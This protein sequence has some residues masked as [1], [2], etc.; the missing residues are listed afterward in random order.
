MSIVWL[1]LL[2][3]PNNTIFFLFVPLSFLLLC[4]SFLLPPKQVGLLCV[5]SLSISLVA[6]LFD[7][8]FKTFSRA[9]SLMLFFYTFGNLK[10]NTILKP[11]I[12]A[13]IAFMFITQFAYIIG[14]SPII[15]FIQTFYP[16]DS[17]A[18]GRDMYALYERSNM[19]GFGGIRLGGVFYNPNQFVRFMQMVLITMLCEI[20]QFKKNEILVL[21]PIFAISII[22]T[23][24]RTSFVVSMTLILAYM[25]YNRLFT[26]RR[27]MLMSLIGFFIVGYVLSSVDL[28]NYRM[29]KVNQGLDDSFS[30][31]TKVLYHYLIHDLSLSQV[32]FGNL[33]GEVLLKIPGAHMGTPTTSSDFDIGNIIIYYGFSFALA[34][35]TFFIVSYKSIEPKYRIIFVILL[36]MLSSSIICSYRMAP[37]FFI[38]LNLCYNK[39]KLSY[40]NETENKRIIA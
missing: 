20:K 34:L 21:L 29:L 3:L 32:L 9:I 35:I 19:S 40:Q 5:L 33:S 12:I 7:S 26:A 15:N 6:N 36:W 27:V 39:S 14:F 30:G 37:I 16:Y 8:D 38:G 31:K 13:A 23:G 10:G 18:S 17:E 1:L 4:R 28:D 2:V 22:A 24:S 11:Y 25:Y